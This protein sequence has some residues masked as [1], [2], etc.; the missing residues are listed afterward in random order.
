MFWLPGYLY[1]VSKSGLLIGNSDSINITSLKLQNNLLNSLFRGIQ[2]RVLGL[3]WYIFLLSLLVVSASPGLI[4]WLLLLDMPRSISLVLLSNS[5]ISSS[6]FSNGR[7][8]RL[9][10]LYLN[11]AI[12]FDS[13][14][15]GKIMSILQVLTNL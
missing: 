4:F 12:G 15:V 11:I 8:G 5:P 1:L 9:V 13:W 7:C 2:S 10:I 14:Q 3:Y 6:L